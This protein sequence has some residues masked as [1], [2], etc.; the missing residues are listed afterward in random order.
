MPK[1]T[2]TPRG[3][4]NNNPCNIRRSSQ[5]WKGK[6]TDPSSCP[7]VCPT[8][9]LDTDFEQFTDLKWG[10]RAALV[11]L[12]TYTTKYHLNTVP[13]IIRRW[14][15]PTEN[16][17]DHYISFV[18]GFGQLTP[19]QH[20]KFEHRGAICRLVWSMAIYECGTYPFSLAYAYS[21]YD[22]F[23]PKPTYPVP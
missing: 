17:V 13:A 7:A 2:K 9:K 22:A 16:S 18:C 6:I 10:V 11:I 12:R 8:G 3:L 1:N 5:Q 23:F 21:V 19:R 4:R 14:A 15:P 20:I